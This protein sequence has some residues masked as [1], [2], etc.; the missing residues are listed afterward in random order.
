MLNAIPVNFK[1][2]PRPELNF[3]NK[4]HGAGGSEVSPAPIEMIE[5]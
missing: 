1:K 4:Q 5:G 3:D 2:N